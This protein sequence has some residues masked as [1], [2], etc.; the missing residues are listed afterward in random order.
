MMSPVPPARHFL[1]AKDLIDARYRDRLEVATL[2][3]AACLSEAHF[4]RE[5]RAAFGETPMRRRAHVV[6]VDSLSIQYEMRAL[7]F[8]SNDHDVVE[9]ERRLGA[10]RLDWIEPCAS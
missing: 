4:S 7:R 1:R 8:S 6:N 2:A 9:T 10:T 3:C 5:F